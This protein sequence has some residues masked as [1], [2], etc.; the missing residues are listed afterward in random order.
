[1]VV[2]RV[3]TNARRPL[4][5]RCGPPQ[6]VEVRHRDPRQ[7]RKL[8]LAILA[9][10]ALHDPPRRWPAHPLV[11]PVHFGQQRDVRRGVLFGK[12]APLAGPRFE[13]AGLVVLPDQARDLGQA[14]SGHLAQVGPDHAPLLLALSKVLLLEQGRFHPSVDFLPVLASELDCLAGL[15]KRADHFRPQRFR[16]PHPNSHPPQ[17]AATGVPRARFQDHLVLETGS[18]SGSSCIGQY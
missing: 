4:A 13:L 7:P 12:A 2:G 5:I 17:D 11:R 1:M 15:Q 3:G 16:I 8:L 18:V 14:L 6:V 10:L 9:V